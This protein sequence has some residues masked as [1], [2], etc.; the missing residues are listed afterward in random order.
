KVENTMSL[1]TNVKLNIEK[2]IGEI[3][4]YIYGQYFEHLEDCIYPSVFDQTSKHSNEVGLRQD[5]IQAAK[6]LTVPIIRWPGGCFAD[7]YHWEDGIGPKESRPIR[8]NWHWGGLESN[9]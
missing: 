3:N 5:V 7:L 6:E 8:Q 2:K 9:Q 1:H 4:P